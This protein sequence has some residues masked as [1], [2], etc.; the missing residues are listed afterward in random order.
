M[1]QLP[2]FL[3]AFAQHADD[4]KL[5][6]LQ[7][8]KSKIQ[9]ALQG[10]KG[11]GRIDYEFL[12]TTTVDELYWQLNHFHGQ[13]AV[14]HFGGHSNHRL[15]ALQD[16]PT[17]SSNLSTVLGMQDQLKLVFLNGCA[18]AAQ[19]Q[20]LWDKGVKAVIATQ[21]SVGDEAA[22]YFSVA[23]Y[24]AAEREEKLEAGFRYCCGS[25]I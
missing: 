1:P 11:A 19:V 17:R 14:F 7:V 25:T 8:E 2:L 10:A 24:Q 15:L 9:K 3:F 4:P 18:N 23:F 21:E 22:M 16:K 20:E 12:D 5:E 13:L 6:Q